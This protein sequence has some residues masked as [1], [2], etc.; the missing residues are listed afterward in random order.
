MRIDLIGAIVRNEGK[1]LRRDPTVLLTFTLMPLVVMA[2]VKPAYQAALLTEGIRAANG[3]EQAVPGIAILFS[4]FLVGIV[5]YVMFREHGWNTWERLTASSAST[6]E[7]MIGKIIVPFLCLI[8]QLAVLLGIGGLVFGLRVHG[9]LIG[10]TLVAVLFAGALVSLGLVLVAVCKSIL[11]MQMATYLGAIVLAGISGALTPLPTV[12]QW[13]RDVAPAV[14]S[15]WAM[16]GFRSMILSRQPW[17]AI[18]EPLGMLAGFTFLFA[19]LAWL[20][21]RSGDIKVAWAT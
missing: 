13:A 16:A 9:S 15:Y 11:Q 5:G 14:P 18:A 12:P 2:F 8:A 21:F 19:S 1:I 10:V 17:S 6:A 3:A 20:F 7:I 4:L